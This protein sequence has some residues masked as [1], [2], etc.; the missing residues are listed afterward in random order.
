MS[1]DREDDYEVVAQRIWAGCAGA[2]KPSVA[3][4]ALAHCLAAALANMPIVE[5][6]EIVE[7]IATS[8][9]RRIHK[10]QTWKYEHRDRTAIGRQRQH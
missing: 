9:A 1:D 10:I 2:S 8:L 4:N 5:R 6:D 3:V 7:A